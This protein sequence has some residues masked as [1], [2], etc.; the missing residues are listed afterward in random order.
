[1][2]SQDT[3][4]GGGNKSVLDDV[5][6]GSMAHLEDPS[7]YL[8]GLSDWQQQMLGMNASTSDAAFG[9]SVD[10]SSPKGSSYDQGDGSAAVPVSVKNTFLNF[11]DQANMLAAAGRPKSI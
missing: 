4:S 11:E 1:M 9:G 2:P 7:R 10:P 8:T 6:P 5:I 3:S